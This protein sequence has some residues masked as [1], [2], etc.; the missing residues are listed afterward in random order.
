MRNSMR[1]VGVVSLVSMALWWSGLAQAEGLLLIDNPARN[2]EPV[3]VYAVVEGFEASDAVAIRQFIGDWQGTYTPQSGNNIAVMAARAEVGV[4]WNGYR[5]GT[6]YRAQ[7]LVQANRDTSD[8]VRAYN[9][10]SGYEAGR[11]YAMDYRMSGFAANG[12]RLGRGQ[13]L[14]LGTDWAVRWG[15]SGSLLNG[16]QLKLENANGQALALNAQDFNA[17]VAMQTTNSAMDTRD[18]TQFNPFVQ[19]QQGFGGQGYAVDAGAFFQRSDG[20]Q[21]EVA[22]NDLAGQMDWKNVPMRL[23]NYST[24]TK[25][26]DADGYVHYNPTAT[27]LSSYVNTT[28]MLDPKLWLAVSYPLGSTQLQIATSHI[29]DIWLPELNATFAVATDWRLKTGYDVRFGTLLLALQHPHFEL[30]LRT[31]DLALGQAKG[32]GLRLAVTLPL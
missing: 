4:Q 26:Y 3:G 18:P 20:L 21:I 27:T 14:D 15:V 11:A 30:S 28:Q 16:S 24:A 7:A 8:L 6:L 10:R 29:A 32:Y 5:L 17:N 23:T 13:Q 1:L 2:T 19:T 22:V 9:T 12:L 25:S 31:D